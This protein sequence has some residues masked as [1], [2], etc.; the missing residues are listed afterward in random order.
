MANK[1]NM[2]P[3]EKAT[4][5][6]VITFNWMNPLLKLGASR[7]LEPE[8]IPILPFQFT[9]DVMCNS[10]KIAWEE[11]LKESGPDKATIL[12]AL[13]KLIG[14]NIIYSTLIFTVNVATILL[15][16]KFVSYLLRYLEDLPID[17]LGIHTGYGLAL[18]LTAMSTT[19][20][21]TANITFYFVSLCG[22]TIRNGIVSIVFDKSLKLSNLS[23]DVNSTGELLT[24][25]SVDIERIWLFITFMNWLWAGPIM[26]IVAMVLL[27]FENG[28]SA[29]APLLT[30]IMV[31]LIQGKI[32]NLTGAIRKEYVKYTDE[33]IKL[34]NESLQGIRVVKLYAWELPIAMR[35]FNIRELEVNVIAY[36]QTLRALNT[37]LTFIGPMLVAF[38]LFMCYV[39]IGR[40]L[41]VPQVYTSYALLNLVRLPLYLTPQAWLAYSEA[42]V[43]FNRLTKYLLLDNIDEEI[44]PV[45]QYLDVDKLNE[46]KNNVDKL[47][48]NV[49]RNN[50]NNGEKGG[51]VYD[52]NSKNELKYTALDNNFDDI[53][54]VVM[55]NGSQQ[56]KP[57]SQLY[58]YCN[59]N[60][61]NLIISIKNAD[62]SYNNIAPTLTNISIDIRIGEFIAV[63]GSVGSGKSSLISSITGQMHCVKGIVNNSHLNGIA[64]VAQEHWI[65]N[66]S[67]RDNIV[68]NYAYDEEKYISVL[69]ASQLSKDLL[70]LPNADLTFIGE[71]GLNLSGGQ[72][73]RVSI[74][75]AFYAENIDL[76]IFDDA[77]ASVDAH[78]AHS[79]FE[80]G[81]NG[82]LHDKTRI[83]ALSSNYHFLPSF[84]KIIVMN[85]GT[86][87]NIGTYKEIAEKYPQF[88]SNN[89]IIKNDNS[90]INFNGTDSNN[91]NDNFNSKENV[92]EN[93]ELKK[94]TMVKNKSIFKS[95]YNSISQKRLD[96]SQFM[97]NEDREKG[98]VTLSTY[99]KYFSSISLSSLLCSI[100]MLNNSQI[101][102]QNN[103]G[104]NNNEDKKERKL[105]WH[106]CLFILFL[107]S[108]TQL[109]RIYSDIW[110]GIWAQSI[111]HEDDADKR[112]LSL[113]VIL[114]VGT[115]VVSLLRGLW[116][117]KCCV[118]SSLALH[119]QMLQSVL[120]API[121]LF[122][123]IT[124]LGRIINRF[125]KDLDNVDSI[126]P[127]I[128]LQTIQNIFVILGIIGICLVSS[129][130]LVVLFIPIAIIF[131]F[132]Y[133]YYIKS[134]RELKRLDSISRSPVYSSFGEA[135][136]GMATIRAYQQTSNF[137]KKFFALADAQLKN[138]FAFWMAGRW[139]A[140]RL[141]L[142]AT[143]LIFSVA[144]LAV[145][146]KETNG[147]FQ[148]NLIGIALVYS[149][150]LTSLLQWT[151]RISIETETL[152][153]SVERLIAIC[154]IPS[155]KT[156]ILYTQHFKKDIKNKQSQQI[157][158][159]N[160]DCSTGWPD[161]GSIQLTNL[162]LR[163]RPDLDHVLNG[164][165]LFIP[166][167]AKVGVCGRT[168]AGK[169][170][171]MLALFRLVEP[172]LDSMIIIDNRNILE[173]SL[174]ELRS[175]ITIIPQDPVMFSG[176]LRYNLDPFNSY[177]DERIW[178]SLARVH[179][180][181]D[182]VQSF[183]DKLDHIIS[184]RG[185]NVSLGQ[186][187]LICIAR[188]L[189]R[190]SKVIILDE[191]TASVDTVTDQKI[192]MTIR[193]EFKS[194]TVLTIAHRIET[195]AD[196]DLVVVMDNG[197]VVEYGPPLYLLDFDNN[198]NNS[199]NSNDD[200]INSKESTMKEIIEDE[201]AVIKDN[202]DNDKNDNNN[203]N[204]IIEKNDILE[205]NPNKF[206][207]NGLFRKLVDSMGNDG[208]ERF[209]KIALKD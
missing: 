168:G 185:E 94:A 79:L 200:N 179:I 34:T 140:L 142:V 85:K 151:V 39:L 11:S 96:I 58:D 93:L 109:G 129:A 35:V 206:Y 134:S 97:S 102:I 91:N 147:N 12:N 167:G 123:D 172:E 27:F 17:Y 156:A 33:R 57:S 198:S 31:F 110:V 64:L 68:F 138:Y 29:I 4:F 70:V 132:I 45:K 82:L 80:D 207:K 122:F 83:V 3:Y 74:A 152:M 192:Q 72:K 183:P 149:L 22:F 191:A 20:A 28:I 78:V 8:D 81:I 14:R 63:V 23:K 95:N 199:N 76:Y 148:A 144:M 107:F 15:Q 40:T 204:S 67:L 145:I 77:L 157:N 89:D 162:K 61:D 161:K 190:N 159:N 131:Y 203:N 127:D 56:D 59:L 124:P 5:V 165:N 178:I 164:V 208:K 187:Q 130:Y 121:N 118:S 139:L 194:C 53:E 143:C 128:Y 75:R 44:T 52:I 86:I 141:D 112:F 98:A 24:M 205:I 55:L 2:S 174:Y 88:A 9:S 60:E 42:S 36:Y 16:P 43:S 196:Y 10:L 92:E 186:R 69:D 169:S 166:C 160:T 84:S 126:L 209:M 41:T 54:D 120:S 87:E 202:N 114:V 177:S 26:V 30:M 100:S 173:L 38:S 101:I 137:R 135:L 136:Q 201:N 158:E 181:D 18:A 37:C 46:S 163:Y 62:F 106:L 50:V 171:L 180:K 125:S 71:R 65:Q 104:N 197:S 6:D 103:N 32:S 193:E 184:E 153:T 117:I 48:T 146:M 115:C 90:N 66:I 1:P 49:D 176:T 51:N 116:F 133:S 155:E 99:I 111:A 195:I 175:Q 170:S 73:A 113:Y 21:L 25:I 7:P 108:I 188:A 47:N 119:H 154:N 105:D 182:I 13:W 19:A 150:Q 189:L